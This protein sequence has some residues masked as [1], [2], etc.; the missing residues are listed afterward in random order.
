[1]EEKKNEQKGLFR[2]VCAVGVLCAAALILLIVCIAVT[3]APRFEPPAFDETARL[4]I[5]TV[6]EALGWSELWQEGMEFKAGICGVVTVRDGAAEVYFANRSDG[7]WLKL[8]VLNGAGELLGETGLVRE[9]MYV[10]AVPLTAQ[11]TDGETVSM[12]V[13]AYEPDSYQSL[14]A[15]YL[16]TTLTV[17]K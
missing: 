2:A 3:S 10:E 12:K 9:D 4:G 15:I 17:E 11:V 13:M 8:R 7:A 16:N 14:G 5:P 1:M 6:D